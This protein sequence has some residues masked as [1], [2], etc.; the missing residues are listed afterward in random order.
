VAVIT[1]KPRDATPVSVRM[2]GDFNAPGSR[3]V[4]GL[5]KKQPP[6]TLRPPD[7][8]QDYDSARGRVPGS[9][10]RLALKSDSGASG[11]MRRWVGCSPKSIQRDH[12]A[13][14]ALV[15]DMG[16]IAYDELGRAFHWYS[17]RRRQ[18]FS[19]WLSDND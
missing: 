16:L 13:L 7:V 19:R 12:E 3:V 11:G 9:L 6:K 15:G 1:P 4:R 8:P 14:R 2:K 17:D 10:T 18:V 5:G